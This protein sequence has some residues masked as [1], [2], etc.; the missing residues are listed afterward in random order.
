MSRSKILS[1]FLASALVFGLAASGAY[2]LPECGMNPVPMRMEGC[3]GGS[4]CCGC[5][6]GTTL[7]QADFGQIA[8]T[9][10]KLLPEVFSEEANHSGNSLRQS[11]G[12]PSRDIGEEEP[13]HRSK[14]YDIYSD[15]RL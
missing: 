4:G 14:L 12:N 7:P 6:M 3:A 10:S 1:F 8:V 13:S 11:K 9:S 5:E 2:A 15:Y